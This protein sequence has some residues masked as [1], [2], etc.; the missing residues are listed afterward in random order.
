MENYYTAEQAE[1]IAKRGEAL[2]AAGLRKAEADWA[3]II[4][5]LREY[6]KTG[7]PAMDARVV[8][9]KEKSQ[10][11]IAAFTGGD[12]GIAKGLN[13]MWKEEKQIHGFDTGKMRELMA[14]MHGGEAGVKGIE[15]Y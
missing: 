8:A 12:P 1:A 5:L 2:G 3:E 11:L 6:K 9:L 10:G 14:Y 13:K 4:A 15:K 7:V